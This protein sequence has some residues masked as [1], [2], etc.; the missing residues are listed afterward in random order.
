VD[1][2]G[3]LFDFGGVEPMKSLSGIEHDGE[4]WRR[5]LACRWVRTFESGSC[6]AEQFAEGVVGDWALPIT[7]D[8]FLLAF[9]S[10]LG[11]P[12]AGADA[13]LFP[14]E[15]DEPFGLVMIEA[16][17]S[18]TPVIGFRRASVPEIVDDGRTGFVVDDVEAMADAIGRLGEIDRHECRLAAER[19]FTVD[20]MVDDVEAMY[21]TVVGRSP[22]PRSTSAGA[23]VPV[24]GADQASQAEAAVQR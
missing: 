22:L 20:R 16:L 21:R 1:V 17:A 13:L 8:A 5:W 18:G 2:R 11:G 6:S 7:P 14:I 4:M 9:R 24:M 15:W 10:W 12:L 19:R 3:V 23:G